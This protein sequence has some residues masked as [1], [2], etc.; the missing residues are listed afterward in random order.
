MGVKPIPRKNLVHS[1]TLIDQKTGT[2]YDLEKVLFQVK[3][4][5]MY[6]STSGEEIV[7]YSYVYVDVKNSVYPDI[8]LFT[9]GNVIAYNGH[10]YTIK[11]VNY[12]VAFKDHHLEVLLV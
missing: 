3:R 1:A 11:N 5:V 8:A 12:L 4:G 6:S 2:Q 10:R 9:G 7:S